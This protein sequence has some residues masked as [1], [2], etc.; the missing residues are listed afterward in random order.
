MKNSL[1][2]DMRQGHAGEP[3]TRRGG[4]NTQ[5]HAGARRVRQGQAG[6]GRSRQGQ[7]GTGRG[8]GGVRGERSQRCR[9]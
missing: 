1:L 3:R 6:A 5:G 8:T 4:R 2:L 9:W 7:A